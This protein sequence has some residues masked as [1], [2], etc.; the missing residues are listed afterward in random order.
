[1]AENGVSDEELHCKQCTKPLVGQ[2]YVRNNDFP[3]C[4]PCYEE[5]FANVCHKCQ[6]KIGCNSKDLSHKDMHW[7]GECFNCFACETSLV[8]QY[9]LPHDNEL[10][11][12]NC[13]EEKFAERCDKCHNVFKP[14]TRKYEHRGQHY[15][16]ECFLC[17]ECQQPI[18]KE[19]FITREQQPVC[20]PCYD[21]KFAQRCSQCKE[22][23]RQGGVTYKNGTWH[24][25][26][27]ICTKCTKQLAGLKFITKEN[28]PFC[29]DCYVD[30]FAKKCC[31][32]TK[33]IL[34]IGEKGCKFISFDERH[35][36]SECFNCLQ[37]KAN[38]VGKGFHTEKDE[39]LCSSCYH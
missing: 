5:L 27:F 14:G 7:H 29:M 33:P 12:V 22:V 16:E 8:D 36:H 4:L 17:S 24:K 11:C 19:N 38:L 9:F 21:A 1:M 35:W 15:H 10:F 20:M 39:I 28:Q 18:G 26:C 25:E 30:S 23:I 34:G 2:R 13:Y 6:T 37:C 3:Y 32:C 31:M